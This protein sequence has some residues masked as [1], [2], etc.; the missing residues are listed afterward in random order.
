MN[1]NQHKKSSI[2]TFRTDGAVG[3]IR[4]CNTAVRTGNARLNAGAITAGV[5]LLISG[6]GGHNTTAV[7]PSSTSTAPAAGGSSTSPQGTSRSPRDAVIAA[8]K[9]FFGA[10][11]KA[12]T[13]P[14]EQA[15]L[16]LRN[17]VTGAYLDWE[18]RQIMTHQAEHQ[19]PWGKAIVH[20]TRVELRSNTAKV[21]D[22][23]DA[24]NAGLSDARTHK[25]LP[26]T[27]G[28]A[29]RNLVADMTRE[30]DGRWRVA[31][32]KQYRTACHVP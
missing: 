32:L 16:I 27:R 10:A 21:H 2:G 31:G 23:Q 14:P 1:A 17:Y 29:N 20:V 11:G 5:A 3:S 22:C 8:Y 19:E 25:L 18:I 13:A 4:T 9:D 7:L 15:R 12:I 28:T 26:N 6:C 30:G 24:S